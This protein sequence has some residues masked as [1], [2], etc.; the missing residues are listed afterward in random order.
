MGRP[1]LLA[2]VRLE[3]DDPARPPDGPVV[4]DQPTAE[5]RPTELE[6]RQPEDVGSGGPYRVL[7]GT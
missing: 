3:L 1:V 2:D 4:P 7:T 5:Q 6:G